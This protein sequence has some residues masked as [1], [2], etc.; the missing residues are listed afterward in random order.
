MLDVARTKDSIVVLND[1][2]IWRPGLYAIHHVTTLP[3]PQGSPYFVFEAFYCNECDSGPD[4]WIL[5]A[6]ENA[7]LTVGLPYPGKHIPQGEDKPYG[8]GRTFVGQC[9]G[10]SGRQVIS[11]WHVDTLPPILDSV[12]MVTVDS[13]SPRIVHIMK[14]S[15]LLPTVARAIRSHRCRELP[16]AERTP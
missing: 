15:T 7:S 16:Q 3:A 2:S 11:V 1:G 13:L 9:L 5:R 4:L 10:D 14:S 8:E 6:H 12:F